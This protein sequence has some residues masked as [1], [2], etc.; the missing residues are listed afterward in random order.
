[1][2]G[3]ETEGGE[4]YISVDYGTAESLLDGALAGGLEKGA[5]GAPA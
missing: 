3:A 1:M 2:S 4:Y 5:G